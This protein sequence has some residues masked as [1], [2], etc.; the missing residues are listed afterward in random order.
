MER[1][2]WI[3]DG[4]LRE[5]PDATEFYLAPE[6]VRDTSTAV[7]QHIEQASDDALARIV[8]LEDKL[9]QDRARKPKFQKPALQAE[10]QTQ[11][12]Q[13]YRRLEDD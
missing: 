7:A 9:D 13:L 5:L 6:A 8:E 2:L 11:L 10:W 3:D 4:V 1:F 12:E